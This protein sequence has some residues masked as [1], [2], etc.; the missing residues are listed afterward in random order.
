MSWVLK[1]HKS[2][3]IVTSFPPFTTQRS[4]CTQRGHVNVR[5]KSRLLS[6]VSQMR[7]Q[8]VMVFCSRLMRVMKQETNWQRRNEVEANVGSQ[9]VDNVVVMLVVM[10]MR[11]RLGIGSSCSCMAMAPVE[12]DG[13]RLV[14]WVWSRVS[15]MLQRV[16]RRRWAA[17]RMKRL[18]MTIE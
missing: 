12:W 6:S 15:G 8:R 2:S 16:M 4:V 10:V 3:R 5:R 18:R 14:G 13:K 9:D 7:S 17:R 1:H 11:P